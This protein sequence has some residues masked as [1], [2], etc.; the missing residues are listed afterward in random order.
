MKQDE[1]DRCLVLIYQSRNNAM[2]VNYSIPCDRVDRHCQLPDAKSELVN[3]LR[4]L[5]DDIER[6]YPSREML[7]QEL[8]ESRKLAN[9]YHVQ[10]SHARGLLLSCK[11]PAIRNAIGQDSYGLFDI[12][13]PRPTY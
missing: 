5:A 9:D 13:P 8:S 7:I 1:V 11:C 4:T 12:E 6:K 3:V 2:H 10:L